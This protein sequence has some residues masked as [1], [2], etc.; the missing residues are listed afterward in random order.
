MIAIIALLVSI[1]LPALASA[2]RAAR[3]TVCMANMQQLGRAQ[4]SYTSDFKG[5]IAALNGDIGQKGPRVGPY[6]HDA[7]PTLEDLAAQA[8]DLVN[9]WGGR[10]ANPIGNFLTAQ[11]KT[12]V[13][14]EQHSHLALTGYL[15]QSL[16]T[17]VAVCPEDGPRLEW[18]RN[19]LNPK[20]WSIVPGAQASPA[21]VWN[22]NNKAWFAYSSS[23]Q[24]VPA[25]A[26]DQ[27]VFYH[28]G[29]VH[30]TY[31]SFQKQGWLRMGKQK[32]DDVLFASQKVAM[33]DTQQRHH[34]QADAFFAYKEASVPLLFF[35]GSV[36]D[37]NTEDANPGEDIYRVYWGGIP[38]GTP[39]TMT[40]VPDLAFESPI[41]H[42]TNKLPGYY[43][44]TS[45]L[46]GIDFGG[47][48]IHYKVRDYW[49]GR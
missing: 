7:W 33:Y 43:R 12:A 5:F 31:F 6:N 16:P 45:D 47:N 29:N 30:D 37:R 35:D 49:Q 26:T 36:A 41:Q 32:I 4:A 9:S 18:S 14:V 20:Q 24:L 15:T 13:I 48:P 3:K 21:K 27:P 39:V 2:R 19:P 8:R 34:G 44:W 10:E 11:G 38:P 28:Q 25:A 1:L 46:G 40:Y 22:K 17:P 23:Y 42:E